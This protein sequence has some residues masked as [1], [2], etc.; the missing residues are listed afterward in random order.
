MHAA[1]ITAYKDFPVLFRLVRSLLVEDIAIFIH[2][3]AKADYD[4][5]Q[6]STLREFAFVSAQHRI[7][8]GSYSHLSAILELLTAAIADE[9]IDYVHLISGQDFP[10]KAILSLVDKD[11]IYMLVEPVAATDLMVRDR[12]YYRKIFHRIEGKRWLYKPLNR[13][14]LVVQKLTKLK[15]YRSEV[16]GDVYKGVVWMSLP[17]Q[18]ARYIME[19]EKSLR[20]REELRSFY[21]PEEFFFQTVIMHS[22]FRDQVVADNRRYTVWQWKHGTMPAILDDE[23]LAGID[24]SDALF[25]RKI[26]SSVSLELVEILERRRRESVAAP[27]VS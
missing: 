26:D 12:L 23:D 3:D 2:V 6:L 21:L 1:L 9:R 19:D 25:A 14:M 13:L 11:K 20:Y 16:Y 27:P 15:R 7:Y 8:W 24:A 5:E 10:V 17:S 4:E 22:P 18:V